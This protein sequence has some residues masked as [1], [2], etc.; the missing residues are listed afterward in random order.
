MPHSMAKKWYFALAAATLIVTMLALAGCT[1]AVGP[2]GPVGPVGPDGV[3]GT[4][5]GIFSGTITN[6]LTSEALS[7]VSA[8]ITAD[9]SIKAVTATTATDGTFS[10]NLPIG[11][12]SVSFSKT[13]FTSTN[14]TVNIISGQTSTRTI[15]LNPV[16]N[17]IVSAGAAQAADPQSVVSLKVSAVVLDNS[18]ISAYEWTQ[19]SGVSAKINNPSANSIQVTLGTPLDYKNALLDNLNLLD[20]WVVQAINPY[21]LA[22]AEDAVFQVTVTTS[23]GKYS[24]NV[25]VSANIPYEVS[26]GLK[27]VPINVPVLIHGKS[28]GLYDWKLTGPTGSKATIDN[29]RDQNPSFTPDL[30]GEYTLTENVSGTTITIYGGTWTGAITG[31]DASGK[32]LAANCTICHNGKTAPDQFADWSATGHAA[33]LAD[34]LNTSTHYGEA[35]FSCHS[36]GFDKAAVNG[37]MD[38]AP[39]YVAFLASGMINKP[40]PLNWQNM[41]ANYPK[42]AQLANVQCENCHGPDNNTI[43]PNTTVNSERISLSADLCASCHGEPPRHGRFQQWA[44]SGH[45]NFATASSESTSA[46]C[47]RCHTAQGFLTWI[48]QADMTLNLQG[49]KG[50]M[51]AAELSAI[52]TPDNAQPITCVVCHDPHEIGTTSGLTTNNA[53][54][55][56]MDNT[57]LLP[58]GYQAT[59]VGKGA[60]CITCHNTRNGLHDD[61]I[62]ITA[63]S[64]PHQAAQ[65][66]VLMGQNA[67]FVEDQRSPH[68]YIENTCVTCHLDESPAPADYSLPDNSTNH[69]FKASITI[70]GNCHTSTLNGV[71]L[72][73]GIEA[74]LTKLSTAMGIY[75]LNKLPD[76]FTVQDYTAHIYN[77][78]SYD[79]KSDTVVI[80]KANIVSIASTEPH[81]Q[82]GFT[83]TLKTPV[84]VTYKPSGESAHTMSV[85]SVT[86]QLGNITT[87]GTNAVI[88]TSDNL[89]KAGW[90]YFL[91]E[92][93]ASFGI[94]NPNFCNQVLDASVAA[95]K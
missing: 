72:Q 52:V 77:K 7:G 79:V 14:Q 64:A 73:Q 22:Q 89:V 68:S 28:S 31:L 60:I 76:Q 87:D 93:D 59:E 65:G 74:K 26:T 16:A 13:N 33:I 19:V 10:V 83:I 39:D 62:A 34:N 66:D 4:S 88:A 85:T 21:A 91:I 2:A 44:E 56:F 15:A 11:S 35:C 55:R 51:T 20:R 75:L 45:A 3:N 57:R 25:T 82:Q 80:A 95:L 43:H 42:T 71:A 9:P 1:G 24:S 61:S 40:S 78:N 49:A 5:T 84:N 70:C 17:V 46:S 12:Y 36:V 38:D 30:I 23:S 63:Y 69:G 32:L 92:G 54:V 18:T 94:H 81:G 37:G 53:N 67:Y 29:K 6:S 50:N 47:A 8:S 90:N 27:V 41:V 58:S 86:V 48:Q